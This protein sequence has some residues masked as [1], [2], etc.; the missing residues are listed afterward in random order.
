MNDVWILNLS[1]ILVDCF[2]HNNRRCNLDTSW[3]YISFDTSFSIPPTV[4]P[5]YCTHLGE[6]GDGEKLVII[7]NLRK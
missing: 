7:E 5:S 1:E 2:E 6:K 4:F 3:N